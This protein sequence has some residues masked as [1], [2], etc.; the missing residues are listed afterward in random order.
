MNVKIVCVIPAR[1]NSTRFPEKLL[2]PLGGIPVLEH[3]WRTAA[4][5]AGFSEVVVATDSRKIADV[6]EAFGGRAVMTSPEHPNGTSR[7]AEMLERGEMEGDIWVN[8]QGDEPFVSKQTLNDLLSTVGDSEV[9]A[10]TL[11]TK[12]APDELE[13]P[14]A[15]KVVTNLK[16]EALYFSR[17]MIPHNRDKIQG[18]SYYKHVGMYA[19]RRELLAKI[20]TLSI[21]PLAKAESLEQLVLLENGYKMQVIET[22]ESLIGIDT[23][24][25]LINAEVF[26]KKTL[27]P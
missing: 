5:Y 19:Y 10:W 18:V 21:T 16:G 20:P 2:K 25:D 4:S 17:S 24:N 1:L 14:S 23:P 8:L 12:A 6:V 3:A 9:D 27:N 11:K 15:V 13:D 7:M 26:L 22:E